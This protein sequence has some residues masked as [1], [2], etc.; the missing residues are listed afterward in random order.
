MNAQIQNT[1]NSNTMTVVAIILLIVSI[2]GV[3]L[4]LLPQ[5][6]RL[7]ELQ[8]DLSSN[9]TELQNLRSEIVRLENLQDSFEGSEVTMNDVLNLIPSNAQE[10]DVITTIAE[11]TSD[12]QVS[13]NSI[14]FGQAEDAE[15]GINRLTITTNLSGGNR[16][17]IRFLEELEETS[18]KFVVESI[19]VQKLQNLLENMTLTI[20]AYYL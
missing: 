8:A 15:L 6:D 1:K 7:A 12:N 4:F 9:Q 2:A 19:S 16:A 5:R 11:L 3:F 14:S 10:E 20:N 17:L 18:R 13:F